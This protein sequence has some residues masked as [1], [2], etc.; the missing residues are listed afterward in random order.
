MKVRSADESKPSAFRW[1]NLHLTLIFLVDIAEPL[2]MHFIIMQTLKDQGQ[3]LDE[4]REFV[5]TANKRSER[6]KD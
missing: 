6:L 2:G 1:P 3:P 4:S 5:F